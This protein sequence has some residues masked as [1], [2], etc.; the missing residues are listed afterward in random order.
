MTETTSTDHSYRFFNFI[1]ACLL[2]SLWRLV[3]VLVKR[4]LVAER[5]ETCVR[6]STF[7]TI[8]KQEYG[9][10]PPD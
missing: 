2:Y 1:F 10:G 4:S 6:A 8:A 5:A 3:D 9:L 7:L